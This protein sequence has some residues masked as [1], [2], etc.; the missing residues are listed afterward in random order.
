MKPIPPWTWIAFSHAVTAASPA[1][2]FAAA[3]AA[4]ECQRLLVKDGLQLH[5]GIGFTWEHDLH[6]VLKRA[7]TDGYL[8]G[9][10]RE[11]RDRVAELTM[12]RA[13]A[14]A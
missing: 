10:A 4:G 12:A 13:A 3:T 7:K 14:P 1:D 9:T 6:F 8:F 11:H 2:D 5:G